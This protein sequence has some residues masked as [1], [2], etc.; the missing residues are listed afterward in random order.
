MRDQNN[1]EDSGPLQDIGLWKIAKKN[2]SGDSGVSHSILGWPVVEHPP[3]DDIDGDKDEL[4]NST[5][6]R[7]V[8]TPINTGTNII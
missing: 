7:R 6:R 1:R 4:G 5:G 2:A 3:F 8:L